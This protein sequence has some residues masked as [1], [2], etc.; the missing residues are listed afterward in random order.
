[1]E[2]SKQTTQRLQK[3]SLRSKIQLVQLL[4]KLTVSHDGS[5]NADSHSEK[6]SKDS[7]DNVNTPNNESHEKERAHS[8]DPKTFHEEPLELSIMASM[9]QVK[10]NSGTLFALM[11]YSQSDGTHHR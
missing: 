8:F 1:M 10:G 7:G 11:H 5:Y 2:D 9:K 4:D 6:H 3:H